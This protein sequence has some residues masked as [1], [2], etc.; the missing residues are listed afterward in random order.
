MKASQLKVEITKIK[1]EQRSE[2]DAVVLIESSDKSTRGDSRSGAKC[3]YEKRDGKWMGV[4]IEPVIMPP[5]FSSQASDAPGKIPF[6]DFPKYVPYEKMFT[7]VNFK[8]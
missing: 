3:T 5:R 6:S 8:P 1:I 7:D 2:D 4:L